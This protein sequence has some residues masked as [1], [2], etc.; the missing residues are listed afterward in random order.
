MPVSVVRSVVDVP[1]VAEAV[2]VS[3]LVEVVATAEAEAAD[4]FVGVDAVESGVVDVPAMAEA[5]SV[6]ALVDAVATAE[7]EAV[8]VLGGDAVES[9]I[10]AAVGVEAEAADV[11]VAGDEVESAIGAAGGVEAE[12]ADGP[13]LEGAL[14]VEMAVDAVSTVALDAGTQERKEPISEVCLLETVRGLS[15]HYV[16]SQNRISV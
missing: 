5:V 11:F 2:S 4:V 3:A 6:P 7:A 12:P 15:L 1:A 16:V 10:G 13:G 14:L 9:A 8:D